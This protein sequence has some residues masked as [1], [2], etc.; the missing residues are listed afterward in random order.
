MKSIKEKAEE[1]DRVIKR[2]NA[3]E[4]IVDVSGREQFIAGAN[5]VLECFESVL[6]FVA[7]KGIIYGKIKE[8][9]E[10]LKGNQ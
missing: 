3:N 7:K 5:Y 9:I 6:P 8:T 10:Q 4:S 1:Y 2:I